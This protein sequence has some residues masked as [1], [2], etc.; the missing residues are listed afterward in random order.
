MISILSDCAMMSLIV[1]G[2]VV[3]VVCVPQS[4]EE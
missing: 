4:L 1:Y 3:F 2:F